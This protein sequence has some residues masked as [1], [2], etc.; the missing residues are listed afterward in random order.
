[1]GGIHPTNHSTCH[2]LVTVSSRQEPIWNPHLCPQRGT[3]DSQ[4]TGHGKLPR[5]PEFLKVT[6]RLLTLEFTTFQVCSAASDGAGCSFF[7]QGSLAVHG[8]MSRSSL[9]THISFDSCLCP[10]YWV[11]WFVRS[12]PSCTLPSNPSANRK[13]TETFLVPPS[14]HFTLTRSLH[15]GNLLYHPHPIF[16][17]Y[18]ETGMEIIGILN[19]KKGL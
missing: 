17:T 3:P 7:G 1:M 15:Y 10:R 12:H 4:P 13:P 19:R 14:L 11:L 6:L 9:L 2:T 8:R 18:T 5:R 16:N